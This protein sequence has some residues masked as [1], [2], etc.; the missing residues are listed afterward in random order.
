[1]DQEFIDIDQAMNVLKKH[2]VNI[3]GKG[4]KTMMFAHGFGCD[5]NV[6]RYITPAF[7]DNYNIVLFDYIGAGQSDLSAYDYK[8]Y[9]SLQG[10]ADD[11]IDIIHALSMESVIFVGHSVSS[12]IGMLAAIKEP[13]LFDK[14]IMVG[15]S[16]R[17]VNE[18]P[19][20]IGGFSAKDLEGLLDVMDSNYLGWSS[21]LGPAI[22]GNPD[23]PELGQELTN[24]FCATNPDIARHFA[25]VTFWSD[26]R[27]DLPR[28][29]TK[30]LLLQCAEDV[31]APAEV[32]HYLRKE[33]PDSELIL[34][35]ATGHCPHMSAPE[36]TIRTIKSFLERHD[37]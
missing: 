30:S 1:M 8:K 15:P 3:S 19:D 12:M 35:E 24:N 4:D 10:Y 20:Y 11:V 37:G 16:P 25:K 28:L 18:D 26:N 14:L 34:M 17:Y 22:M 33:L 13:A 32:G 31:I 6:W 23:R 21:S 2:N 5:Q 9:D 36:E 27:K 29:T 7:Q